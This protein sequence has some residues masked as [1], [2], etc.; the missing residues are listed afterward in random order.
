MPDCHI[1]VRDV[2]VARMLNGDNDD[3]LMRVNYGWAGFQVCW[4][5]YD[6]LIM[7]TGQVYFLEIN[8]QMVGSSCRIWNNP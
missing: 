5:V 8:T 1:L 2:G 7:Q 4:Q 6:S 3:N